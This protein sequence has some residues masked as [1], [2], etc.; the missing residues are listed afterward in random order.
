[1]IG[2]YQNPDPILRLTVR[3]HP[4]ELA[5]MIHI[6]L[7]S[8]HPSEQNINIHY[9]LFEVNRERIRVWLRHLKLY[10]SEYRH[11]EVNDDNINLYP[12][13][14]I[15]E[16]LQECVTIGDDDSNANYRDENGVQQSE[17]LVQNGI[18]SEQQCQSSIILD[19]NGESIP[20][21]DYYSE[22]CRQMNI[23]QNRYPRNTV[24]M[25]QGSEIAKDSDPKF[26]LQAFPTL[27]PFGCGHPQNYRN[28]KIPFDEYV[29]NQLNL[30]DQTFQQEHT[31]LYVCY[32]KILHTQIM[33]ATTLQCHYNEPQVD[34][35]PDI[36]AETLQ[37]EI[38][39]QGDK[40]R[41]NQIFRQIN[42]IGRKIP[43]S[44]EFKLNN[45]NEMKSTILRYGSPTL[46][47]TITP[48]DK[49][50]FL[51]WKFCSETD[52]IDFQEL[53]DSIQDNK[54][55]VNM[56][57]ANPCALAKFFNVIML[58]VL[59]NLFG[60]KNE[61]NTGIFGRINSYYGLVE[62]QTRATLHIHLCIWLAGLGNPR[63]LLQK[64]KE[65]RHNFQNRLFKY[66]HEIIKIDTTGFTIDGHCFAQVNP[67][68]RINAHH[69]SYFTNHW[70]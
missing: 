67:G 13:S 24:A 65:N 7:V 55:R 37:S 59:E 61:N 6:V 4:N 29:R 47:I 10:N 42:L 17:I 44:Q 43:F 5:E 57:A 14:D 45:R 38:E 40:P 26:F 58:L 19:D 50:N 54:M 2:K 23:P 36:S 69:N 8:H 35:I 33:K 34:F 28:P 70:F 62:A 27:F 3:P 41:L 15:P 20:L 66:L 12:N 51:A 60:W 22:V 68:K 39:N 30:F 52:T 48:S 46:W 21:S 25:I 31:F 53:V 56:C 18:Q 49:T 16:V 11:V 32:C 64:M 9:Q 63:E 1:M